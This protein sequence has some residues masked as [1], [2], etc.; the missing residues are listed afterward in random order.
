V[1]MDELPKEQ[2]ERA[3]LAI[4]ALQKAITGLRF[5]DE[6]TSISEWRRLFPVILNDLNP[7]LLRH[8][9]RLTNC[10]GNS[11]LLIV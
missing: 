3:I 6:G 5:I 4:Q 7:L 11:R 2:T 9:W 10:W 8:F 1:R